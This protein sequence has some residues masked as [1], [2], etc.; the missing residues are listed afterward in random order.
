MKKNVGLIG[1]GKWGSLIKSKLSKIA[2][3][4]FVSGKSKNYLDLI[5]KNDLDW[6]FVATPNS[7]HY[8]VVKECL[9][10]KINVFCEKPLTT[11]FKNA[12]KLFKIAKKNKVK[13]YVSD[14]YFFHKKNIK[15]ILLNNKIKRA[16]KVYGN[17][18]E[19]LYRFMYHDISL[20]YDYIF[21]KKVKSL[22]FDQNKKKKLFNLCLTFTDQKKFLFEYD[23]NSRIKKHSINNINFITKDD[24]LGKMINTVLYNKLDIRFNNSK[25]LFIL[26]FI[27]FLRS[28][29]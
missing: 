2:R 9:N 6:I 18:N 10:H 7:T 1:K 16:K 19:F 8:R 26:K 12:Q 22:K 5:K 15:K 28:K 3:L 13:L 27:S 14:V 20:L 17:D 25:A 21:H 11:N 23:L 29:I 24:A 4:K